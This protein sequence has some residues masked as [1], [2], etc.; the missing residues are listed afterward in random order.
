MLI[1]SFGVGAALHGSGEYD[2][3]CIFA[4]VGDA[5]AER[6]VTFTGIVG[7]IF[8][9]AFGGGGGT[10]ECDEFLLFFAE[11][12]CVSCLLP[13]D[14]SGAQSGGP[15]QLKIAAEDGFNFEGK[16]CF[17]FKGYDRAGLIDGDKKSFPDGK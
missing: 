2:D 5:E 13:V 4:F 7:L 10:E 17:Y 12:K 16:F 3:F 14:V 9:A 15:L 1:D 6:V 11:E 8:A